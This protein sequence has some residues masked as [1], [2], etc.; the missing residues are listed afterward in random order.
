[1]D[2]LDK[3]L[4]KRGHRFC[5]YADDCNI[6]V[7]SKRAGERVLA[8]ISGYL[9]KRLKL[10]V[11]GTKSKVGRPWELKFL[12]YT[13]TSEQKPRL[14]VSAQSVQRLKAKLRV[15]FSRGRGRNIQRV[16]EE[17][18]VILRGWIH[19]F[20][21]AEV[22]NIFEELDG[23]VRRKLRCILWR[24]WKRTYTRAKQLMKRGLTEARSW[25]S[26]QNGRGPWWNAGA[27]HMNEAF[28]KSY[29]DQMNLVSL[30]D[31]ILSIRKPSRTAVYGTVR[32]VV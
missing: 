13:M 30:L 2:E 10:R 15:I 12:G 21:L 8:S 14:R 22:R 25:Q 5:R 32:T 31:I 4:E 18:N 1:L 20:K 24:Q 19:Y 11:N 17:L 29:F 23:W 26:V 28:K 6:Y 3:E 27:S 16:I 9:W 7:K